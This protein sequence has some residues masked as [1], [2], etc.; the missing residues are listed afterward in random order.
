MPGIEQPVGENAHVFGLGQ[1]LGF[2]QQAMAVAQIVA[3]GVVPVLM[4][5]RLQQ[6]ARRAQ[7]VIHVTEQGILEFGV[8][9][10][11][12]FFHQ[13][14][15]GRIA[16]AGMFGQTRHRPQTV[17]WVLIKQGANDFALRRRKIQAGIGDQVSERGHPGSCWM[18]VLNSLHNPLKQY[19]CN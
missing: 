6:R 14:H 8:T 9:T 2:D 3:P 12:E 15:N 10:E 7:A 16:D 19:L 13:P 1:R 17:A 18:R 11:T 5:A 4:G